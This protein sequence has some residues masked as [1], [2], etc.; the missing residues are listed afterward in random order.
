[1][2][3]LALVGSIRPSTWKQYLLAYPPAAPVPTHHIHAVGIQKDVQ[4]QTWAT[5][6]SQF[7]RDGDGGGKIDVLD[8][9]KK[10]IIRNDDCH[11]AVGVVAEPYG[12]AVSAGSDF[13]YERG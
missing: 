6:S 7:G 2:G 1:M 12:R 9:R 13:V 4:L 10:R 3:M 11:H 5:A 8:S